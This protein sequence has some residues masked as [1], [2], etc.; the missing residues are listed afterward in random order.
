MRI[1][2]GDLVVCHWLPPSRS[3]GMGDEESADVIVPGAVAREGLNLMIRKKSIVVRLSYIAEIRAGAGSRVGGYWTES[4]RVNTAQWFAMD[5][6][7][8]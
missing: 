7:L 8:L 1:T 2:R 6:R 5:S 4:R 3:G